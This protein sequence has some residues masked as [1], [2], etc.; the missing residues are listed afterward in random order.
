MLVTCHFP[1]GV[2]RFELPASSSRTRRKRNDEP[3][4]LATDGPPG[5]SH[6]SEPW[7]GLRTGMADMGAVRDT[8]HL[9]VL[10]RRV[11]DIAPAKVTLGHAGLS[12]LVRSR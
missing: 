10:M 1:V 2:G 11:G 12:V 6:P 7:D 5:L 4:L 8:L 9:T 3:T